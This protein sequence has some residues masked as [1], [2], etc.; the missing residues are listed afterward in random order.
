M[1]VTVV[2]WANAVLKYPVSSLHTKEHN[3][4][5][6]CIRKL[7]SSFLLVKEILET[8]KEIQLKYVSLVLSFAL[9]QN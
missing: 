1:N 5:N 6:T 8:N 9:C 4:V 7:F 2:A 3:Y